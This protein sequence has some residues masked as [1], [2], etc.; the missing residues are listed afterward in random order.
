MKIILI[1]AAISLFGCA[2]STMPEFPDIKDHYL[3]EVRN[4]AMPA[5]IL[6]AIENAEDIPMMKDAEVVRC[7]HFEIVNKIP[8]KIKFIKQ[9]AVK[10]CNG[11]GGYKPADS[12]SLLNW[13]EDVAHWAESKKKCFK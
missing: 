5:R 10:E 3:I 12:E 2:N 13:V 6:S 1:L 11:V 4:E 7:L 9:E 8:Y